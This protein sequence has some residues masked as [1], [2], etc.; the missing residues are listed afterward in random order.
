TLYRQHAA[1]VLVRLG[2]RGL[3][4]ERALEGLVGLLEVARLVLRHAQSGID[5]LEVEELLAHTHA[6]LARLALLTLDLLDA[7]HELLEHERRG[8]PVLLVDRAPRV[9]EVDLQ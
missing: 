5:L 9:A 3:L 8:R 2:R 1:V 4:L 6:V 7:A